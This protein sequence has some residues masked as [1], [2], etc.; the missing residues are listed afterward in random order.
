MRP[1]APL[2]FVCAGP[3]RRGLVRLWVCCLL[4]LLPQALK[5]QAPSVSAAVDRIQTDLETPVR[6]TVT[7][8]GGSGEVDTR[9]ITDFDILSQASNSSVQI[10]N[11]RAHHEKSIHYHLLPLRE[12]RLTLPA[13][14]VTV[15]GQRL[16]TAPITVTVT[17]T[18]VNPDDSQDI[19]VSA[20][21]TNTRPW[22]GEQV[23][24]TFRLRYA[25][26]IDNT[27]YEA[28]TFDGFEAEQIGEE[29]ARRIVV[30]GR[31]YQEVTL[32]YLLV[33][34][35]AGSIT[36]APAALR[37]D[38]RLPAIGGRMG[39]D[40]FFNRGR[41]EIKHMK[42][43]P[44][45][46]S[47]RPLP[48]WKGPGRFSGLVGRFQLDAELET[49]AADMGASVTLTLTLTGT[50]NIRDAEAPALAAP[51]GFKQYADQPE[52]DIRLA[53]DGYTGKKVFRTALV[54]TAAG[55][56]T[57]RLS[58]LVYFDTAAGTYRTLGPPPLTLSVRATET[59]GA[60]PSVYS[61]ALEQSGAQGAGKRRVDFT[62]RDIL[63]VSDDL[64]ALET[65]H[66][67]ETT[68]FLGLLFAPGLAVL[69]AGVALKN[70]RKNDRPAAVMARKAVAELKA[71]EK[72]AGTAPEVLSALHRALPYAVFSRA[73][74]FGE[75]LATQEA[76]QLLAD[77]R[78]PPARIAA[79]TDLMERLA[80]ARY[81]T[82]PPEKEEQQALMAETQRLVK[83]LVR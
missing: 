64:A 75:A 62:G 50:G 80:S 55:T 32:S 48:A 29:S 47:V 25:V 52:T 72:A 53:A 8:S 16:Q 12:G 11:G 2:Y 81:G 76:K 65:E 35:S 24:Y 77:S 1:G 44:V 57:L 73:E 10:I 37:C 26:P 13:L 30:N 18:A 22:L 41:R 68:W 19:Q 3:R 15:A 54:P 23:V 67:L 6:L 27:H 63:P 60:P 38:R 20:G 43:E 78:V 42:T 4:L 9:P 39:V 74:T 58:P 17:R 14:P 5:A 40:A 70:A 33:P 7:L 34:L 71:A 61:A 66:T 59:P 56:H 31:Q 36:I 49:P 79:I 46:V 82:L 28:P 45:T 21:I 51:P 69:L 83:E